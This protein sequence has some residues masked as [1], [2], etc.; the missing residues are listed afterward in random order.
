[1]KCC[2]FILSMST[3]IFNYKSKYKLTPTYKYVMSPK[4]NSASGYLLSHIFG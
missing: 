4:W 3:P 2:M 1:M